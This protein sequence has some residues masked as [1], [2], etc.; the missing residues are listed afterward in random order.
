MM[1]SIT[2]YLEVETPEQ[3][4]KWHE[5]SDENSLDEGSLLEINV[6]RTVKI[7]LTKALHFALYSM[8]FL[9]H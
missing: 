8:E 1:K 6:H 7:R 2:V 9:L 5:K 3:G 4:R